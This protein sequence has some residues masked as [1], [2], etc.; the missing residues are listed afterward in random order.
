MTLLADP[1]AA[2][3]DA[4]CHDADPLWD[5]DGSFHPARLTVTCPCCGQTHRPLISP[6]ARRLPNPSWLG[7]PQPL[8][9]YE[10]RCPAT[11]NRYRLATRYPQ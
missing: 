4:G 5:E 9:R 1:P 6:H 8:A 2:L 3:P 7:E 10:A 11:T